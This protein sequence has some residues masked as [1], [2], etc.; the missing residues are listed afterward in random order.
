MRARG[1]KSDGRRGPEN[2]SWD[3]LLR[4]ALDGEEIIAV[5]PE[6]GSRRKQRSVSVLPL[7]CGDETVRLNLF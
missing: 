3:D 6:G 4:F 1:K 2:F 5:T 7:L